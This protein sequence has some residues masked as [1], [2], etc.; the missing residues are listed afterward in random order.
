MPRRRPRK[1]KVLMRLVG[2]NMPET[3]ADLFDDAVDA[4]GTSKTEVLRAFIY[5]FIDEHRDDI[6][7][8][9]AEQAN[10]ER[11]PVAS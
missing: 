3:D 11:L 7:R 9:R 2:A 5:G 6:E 10:Q 8:Y 1:P 4:L